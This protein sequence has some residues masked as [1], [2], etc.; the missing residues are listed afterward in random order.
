MIK[1][2][3][4]KMYLEWINDRHSFHWKLKEKYL[5]PCNLIGGG[6]LQRTSILHNFKDPHKMQYISWPVELC[7][8]AAFMT[9]P[10]N[11][12]LWK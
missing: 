2:A 8:M 1:Y 5:K 10:S 6:C 12:S 11:A 3:C 4:D 7:H 9:L